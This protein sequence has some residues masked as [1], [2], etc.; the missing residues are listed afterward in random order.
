LRKTIANGETVSTGDKM[1][2]ADS[3]RIAQGRS[4]LLLWLRR[5]F[6]MVVIGVMALALVETISYLTDLTRVLLG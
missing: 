5:G 3:L 4:R 1:R 2:F 6:D